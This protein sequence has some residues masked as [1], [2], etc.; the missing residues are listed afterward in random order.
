MSQLVKVLQPSN[1]YLN[2]EAKTKEEALLFVAES[3]KRQGF[4]KESY[5]EAVIQREAVFPTGLQ[6]EVCGVAIP[7]TDTVHVIQEAVGF[8][9]LAEPLTFQM[10]GMNEQQV[11]VSMIFMLAMK[12]P[13]NQLDMLQELT[14]IFQHPDRLIQLQ[15]AKTIKE[16]YDLFQSDGASI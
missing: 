10:M 4:V 1:I 7:H 13:H 3:M 2:V 9:T 16:V 5:P 14:A 8:A 12:E 11:E 6:T 15:Q